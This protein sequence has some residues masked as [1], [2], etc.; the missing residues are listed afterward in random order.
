M[1]FATTVVLPFN[2][3]PF[4][5]SDCNPWNN[6]PEVT[7]AMKYNVNRIILC[8]KKTAVFIAK[9]EKE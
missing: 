2:Y 4:D 6:P 9:C 1:R 3:D 5:R 7:L 8:P